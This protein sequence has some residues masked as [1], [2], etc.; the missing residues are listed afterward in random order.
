MLKAGMITLKRVSKEGSKGTLFADHMARNLQSYQAIIAKKIASVNELEARNAQLEKQV[1]ALL[2]QKE[3]T[4]KNLYAK[5]LCVL[6]EKKRKIREL[7]DE[8]ERGQTTAVRCVSTISFVAF[9]PLHD[10]ARG[11]TVS[12]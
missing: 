3:E 5:F 7:E 11:V 1:Q 10:I 8:A 9:P 2:K 6:N 12:P 4:E